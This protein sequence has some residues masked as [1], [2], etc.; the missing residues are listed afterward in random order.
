MP[1]ERNGCVSL[2]FS[3]GFH[4]L[5]AASDQLMPSSCPFHSIP[6]CIQASLPFKGAVTSL[7]IGIHSCD[8]EKPIFPN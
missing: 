6:L 2:M 4:C 1:S 5:F 7:I 8:T 3:K